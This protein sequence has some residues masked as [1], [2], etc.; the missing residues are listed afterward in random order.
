MFSPRKTPIYTSIQQDLHNKQVDNLGV[1]TCLL[2]ESCFIDVCI[3]LLPPGCLFGL[4]LNYY[5]IYTCMY[6][7]PRGASTCLRCECWLICMYRLVSLEGVL[8]CCVSLGS[9]MG[10]TRVF[11]SIC[12][13]LCFPRGENEHTRTYTTQGLHTNQVDNLGENNYIHT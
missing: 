12:V 3:D 9:S 8:V 10:V 7:F 13:Y 6:V 2:W 4:L 1:Y 5:F 11:V